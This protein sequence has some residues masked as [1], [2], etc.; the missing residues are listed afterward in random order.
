MPMLQR[1]NNDGSPNGNPEFRKQNVANI[2][3]KKGSK[4]RLVEA[5]KPK[6]SRNNPVT[7]DFPAS[8]TAQLEWIEKQND[9]TKLHAVSSL[10]KKKIVIDSLN[11]RAEVL[12][13]NQNNKV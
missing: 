10:A 1:L 4:W 3:L 5:E 8:V 9:I 12:L 11:K 13:K 6:I 7:T 2:L